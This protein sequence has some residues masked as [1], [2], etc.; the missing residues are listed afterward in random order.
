MSKLWYLTK[1]L[2]AYDN[3]CLGNVYE[4]IS[5]IYNVTLIQDMEDEVDFYHTGDVTQSWL[6]F[7]SVQ[8]ALLSFKGSFPE[9]RL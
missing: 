6:S 2:Y 8:Y 9:K 1:K 5:F 7:R 3:L 4:Y